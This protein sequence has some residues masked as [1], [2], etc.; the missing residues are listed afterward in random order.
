[1]ALSLSLQRCPWAFLVVLQVEFFAFQLSESARERKVPVTR[2]GRLLNF[3]GGCVC[4]C[5]CWSL[6]R[7]SVCCFRSLPRKG[8]VHIF[9]TTK[10]SI[11][12]LR[13]EKILN[14]CHFALQQGIWPS[15]LNYW[16]PARCCDLWRIT[17]ITGWWV[18]RRIFVGFVFQLSNENW[19]SFQ[20]RC[21]V[22]P[23]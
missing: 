19:F 7:V 17:W 11:K 23:F 12:I 15:V 21:L 3:G 13:P 1:M 10:V 2:I 16:A 14:Y 4:V 9:M 5:V 18:K 20:G 22:Q 6:R 8:G